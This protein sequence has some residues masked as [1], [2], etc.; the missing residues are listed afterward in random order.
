MTLPV[1]ATTITAA[2]PN[3]QPLAGAA[4]QAHLSGT[5]VYQGV[6][7]PS[8]VSGTTDSQGQCVLNLWPNVLGSDNSKYVVLVG[9]TLPDAPAAVVYAR[10]PNQPSCNIQDHT[11]TRGGLAPVVLYAPAPSN[12]SITKVSNTV[13][14]HT[15]VGDD[16][17]T[18]Y[19]DITLTQSTAAPPAPAPEPTAPT[20]AS[21]EQYRTSATTWKAVPWGNVTWTENGI[22]YSQVV[23]IYCDLTIPAP[24][25]GR[26]WAARAHASGGTY[27]IAP[28]AALESNFILPCVAA[29][30]AV[31][32]VS[33]RHPVLSSTPTEFF[34][35]DFGRAI[36]FINSLDVAF[37]VNPTKGHFLTQSRGSGV[38]NDLLLPDLANPTAS[39]YAGRKSSRGVRLVY[40][41]NPQGWHN[42]ADEAP[43]YLAT[44]SDIDAALAA[45]PPDSRQ[46]NAVQQIATADLAAIPMLVAQYDAT[47]QSGLVSWAQMQAAGGVLHYPNQGLSYKQ[48]YAARGITQKCV[49]TDQSGS[50]IGT[51]FGP[52]LK[53]VQGIEAGLDL[54]WAVSIAFTNHRSQSLIAIPQD[55]SG[56]SV[57]LDGSG[58]IPAVGAGIGG[59]SDKSQGIANTSTANGA[60]QG[61]N[62]NKPKLAQIGANYGALFA[63]STDVL[64][65]QRTNTGAAGCLAAWS[66][67]AL[68]TT[69]SNQTT[70]QVA[71][72]VGAGNTQTVAI[73]GAAPLTTA[74]RR[75][76][77][78]LAS[79]I[80]GA[81]LTG[82]VTV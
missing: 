79:L 17:I 4:V 48:A 81:D 37:E 45:Y 57:A 62:A 35:R 76:H 20:L 24:S 36:Q 2:T 5:E 64:A 69:P 65:C 33:A 7:V 16:G 22:V 41:N 11:V 44:Q 3:G 13:V 34:D 68:V 51:L 14:R 8:V 28:G 43:V 39:T 26:L 77:A 80:A 63:D 61:T 31:F 1:C 9:G 72:S 67:T 32:C 59:I 66:T 75:I 58:G 23:D 42:S 30:M 71:W 49:V 46:R 18:R 73:I 70:N 10:I 53:V 19:Q 38:I 21:L 60:G 29:G 82:T 25:G 56:T 40:A 12:F 50:G 52:F 47:Y 54:P 74:D 78:H 15:L 55:R 27:D 6:V